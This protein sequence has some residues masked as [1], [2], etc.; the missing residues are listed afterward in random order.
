VGCKCGA[1]GK[2]FSFGDPRTNENHSHLQSSDMTKAGPT[3]LQHRVP[4]L[5]HTEG[6]ITTESYALLH[7]LYHLGTRHECYL[8]T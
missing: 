2:C 7:P 4:G 6:I 8:S 3:V 1:S 5:G